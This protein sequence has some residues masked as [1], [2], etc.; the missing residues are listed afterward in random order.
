MP[1]DC[2]NL[3]KRRGDTKN[4]I[5]QVFSARNQPGDKQAALDEYREA[6][7]LLT[8]QLD[9]NPSDA[10][11]ISNIALTHRRI[12]DLLDEKPDEA[13]REFEAAV[14]ARKRL[15]RRDPGNADWRIGLATDDTRLGDVLIRKKDW[16]G[17]LRS[18][19]EA[20]QIVEAIILNN[21][22]STRWQSSPRP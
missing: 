8:Q 6:L 17:A 20:V 13:Q 21:A 10:S 3:S 5:A 12:G 9:G 4:R 11:L 2:R 15:Y 14:E 16:Q 1:V 7:K 22:T 19:N 18:Y